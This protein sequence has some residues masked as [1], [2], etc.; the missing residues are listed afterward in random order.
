MANKK[1]VG[2]V[3]VPLVLGLGVVGG[4]FLGRYVASSRESEGV[5]K[6]RTVL[7]L[8]DAEYVDDLNIDSLMDGIYPDL[9]SSLDPHSAYIAHEDLQ[10]VNDELG[11]SF[12]G[13]GVM[14]QQ[15]NDTVV[16]AEVVAGG[17]AEK[18]GLANGDRILEAD[19]VKLSGVK[20]SSQD[21]FKAL[22][23]PADTKV[24]LKVKRANSKQPLEFEVIRG[25]VPQH[26]VDC[27]YMMNDDTGYVRVSKFA[28]TTYT[29]FIDALADLREKGAKKYVVDLRGNT[30]GFLDQPILMANEFLPKGRLIVYSKGRRA[31]N[32]TMAISDGS[33]A[34]QDAELVVLTN[35]GTASSSEIFAGAIQDNDRGLII[36]RR[37]FG[38][39]LVQ[40]QVV[41]PDSSAVR[42][43]VA[44]YYTPSGRSIQKEY[45]RGEAYKY[46]MDISDR[47]SHGE[48]FSAD[49][50]K[51]DESKKFETMAGRTVYGGGGIM[52][53]VFVPE[54]TTGVTGYY[55][56]VVNRGL[57]Q[58]YAFDLAASRRDE[59]KKAKNLDALLKMLPSDQTLLEGFVA[60]A[61]KKGVP[62]RWYY[63]N[64]SHDLIIR[65]LKALVARDILG[66]SAY[67]EMFNAYDPTVNRALEALE[68]GDS[69]V[70][71]LPAEK[72][73][74]KK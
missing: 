15:V 63:I 40:N 44:R 60:F 25:D 20:A 18:V 24:K 73:K 69:P 22:R 12:S 3:L 66:Y 72:A 1:A 42:L 59:Y 64:Q 61:V 48:F 36:G 19:G 53:D 4:L 74:D 21:V 16:I 23:G 55:I 35:E 2:Y 70:Q 57:L 37:T 68:K 51:L 62:A 38:K 39:G 13:V 41:L 33:G 47:F 43:T 17:P 10:T 14:F 26:S 56:N 11:S 9:L 30:G 7:S 6:L 50:I 34:F 8:I 29:E 67:L 45:K 31:D 58:E 49:S 65:Q 28:A 5:K 27:V 71:I 46:D 32:E 52:P 54:D